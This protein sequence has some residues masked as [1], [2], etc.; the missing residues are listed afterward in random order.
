MKSG[1]RS[2]PL[3]ICLDLFGLIFRGVRDK[4]LSIGFFVERVD[5][6]GVKIQDFKIIWSSVL[7][8]QTWKI[9]SDLNLKIVENLFNFGALGLFNIFI[10]NIVLEKNSCRPFW[11]L[12]CFTWVV[13][14][15]VT[16]HVTFFGYI[17]WYILDSIIL[18]SNLKEV[19]E[20]LNLS[21]QIMSNKKL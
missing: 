1:L 5:L 19:L 17:T 2:L 11:S 15:H 4:I 8:I 12:G 10:L 6:E 13:V 20:T 7:E 21:F 14:G 18:L 9:K 16:C 3:K